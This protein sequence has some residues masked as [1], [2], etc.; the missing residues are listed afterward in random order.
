MFRA[1]LHSVIWVLPQPVFARLIPRHPVLL[2]F[3]EVVEVPSDK[4]DEAENRHNYE[5]D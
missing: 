4:A 1:Y 3:R 2:T 5:Y